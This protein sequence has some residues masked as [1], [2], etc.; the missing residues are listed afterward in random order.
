LSVSILIKC[1]HLVCIVEL[2]G[3][4]SWIQILEQPNIVEILVAVFRVFPIL[5]LIPVFNLDIWRL[6]IVL[7]AMTL[8][9]LGFL[10]WLRMIHCS[11]VVRIYI[12]TRTGERL[13]LLNSH[14]PILYVLI[15]LSLINSQT[16][17]VNVL[18]RRWD[19]RWHQILHVHL[20]STIKIKVRI[21]VF[22]RTLVRKLITLLTVPLIEFWDYVMIDL[23]IYIFVHLVLITIFIMQ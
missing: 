8:C 17:M 4:I 16:W 10:F 9:P 14:V 21:F 6:K 19:R 18:D 2:A 13:L 15:C 12:I 1:F 11:M 7:L 23:K 3:W 5:I 22:S 20:V